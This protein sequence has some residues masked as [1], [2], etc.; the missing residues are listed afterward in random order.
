MAESQ[1]NGVDMTIA[2]LQALVAAMS[3]QNQAAALDGHAAWRAQAPTP[4]EDT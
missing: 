4:L 2:L 1:R 3:A